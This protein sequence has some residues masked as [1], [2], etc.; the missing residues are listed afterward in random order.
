MLADMTVFSIA[1]LLAALCWLA[2]RVALAVAI[3][4]LDIGVSVLQ[5]IALILDLPSAPRNNA[6]ERG[7]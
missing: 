5:Y 4:L 6:V 1:I 2:I 3:V 7:L